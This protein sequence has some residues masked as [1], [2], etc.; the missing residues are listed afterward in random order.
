[1]E[2]DVR[3]ARA[4]GRRVRLADHHAPVAA[5]GERFALNASGE[6]AETRE[7]SRLPAKRLGR[8]ARALGPPDDDAAVRAHAGRLDAI[9]HRARQPERLEAR[10]LAA[11]PEVRA[12]ARAEDLTIRCAALPATVARV[13]GARTVVFG[14]AARAARVGRR[15]GV[16]TAPGRTAL[17]E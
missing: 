9:V 2:A 10:R 14:S 17:R 8:R 5:H 3:G 15:L 12:V 11:R 4:A 16:G 1:G 6:R 13:V 7:G